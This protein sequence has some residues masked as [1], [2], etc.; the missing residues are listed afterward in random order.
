MRARAAIALSAISVT[1]ALAT[2]SPPAA[3]AGDPCG[4]TGT[5]SIESCFSDPTVDST[6]I[7]DSLTALA[8]TSGA[9]DTIRIIMFH[10]RNGAPPEQLATEVVNAR[11]RGADVKVVLD[12]GSEGYRPIEI[13]KAASVPVLV[14]HDEA[15]AADGQDD[16]LMVEDGF[17]APGS[18]LPMN[19]VKLFLFTIG[20][21][22]N[23]VAGSSNMGP[24]DYQDA[25]NDMVRIRGDQSLHSWLTSYFDRVW[26]DD[27]MGWNTNAERDASGDAATSARDLPERAWV[28]PRLK[29]GDPIAGQLANTTACHTDGDSDGDWDKRVWVAISKWSEGARTEILDNLDRLDAAGCDV[30][31]VLGDTVTDTQRR[32][33]R[34]RLSADPAE[35]DKVRVICD[36]HHKFIVIDAKYSGSY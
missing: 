33:V 7:Y 6:R 26:A 32:A 11:Q 3:A 17:Y 21:V 25:W 36:L 27:W 18:N 28:Y 9:G 12:E 8:A 22:R 1:F 23:I 16:C 24:W 14:C 31:V 4:F 34:Q 29:P 10:W 5:A 19:H 13:L 35:S 2:S 30:K 20:G 15:K